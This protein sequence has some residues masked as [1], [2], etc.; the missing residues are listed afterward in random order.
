ML[1]TLALT[2]LTLTV[3]D[4]ILREADELHEY[5]GIDVLTAVIVFLIAACEPK[6]AA[7]GATVL[8][9]EWDNPND[10]AY[11]VPCP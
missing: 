2:K 6:T 5:I 1:F 9:A 3:G 10:G 11:G 7:S 4:G 8:P